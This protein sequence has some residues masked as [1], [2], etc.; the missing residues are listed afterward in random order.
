MLKT[1]R[2]TSK[3]LK[4]F[5]NTYESYIEKY[6]AIKTRFIIKTCHNGVYYVGS[7][8][9][10]NKLF[11]IDLITTDFN[12]S[13]IIKELTTSLYN[14]LQKIEPIREMCKC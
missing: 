11:G 7:C 4:E 10:S 6:S 13:I 12:A 2:F 1:N 14:D 5:L 3:K 9:V 8:T